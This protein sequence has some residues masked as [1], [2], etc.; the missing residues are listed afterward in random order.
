LGIQSL[1]AFTCHRL[2]RDID[3][4]S[5]VTLAVCLADS[6]HFRVGRHKSTAT[7]YKILV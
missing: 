4:T 5:D 2:Y 3:K 1:G 7:G 6:R